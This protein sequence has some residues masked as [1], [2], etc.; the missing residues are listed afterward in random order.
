MTTRLQVMVYENRELREQAEFDGPVELGRQR[1]RDEVLFTRKKLPTG[2]RWV[3]AERG[4]VSVGRNQVLLEPLGDNRARVRNGSDRQ[5]IRFLD[6]PD[7]GPGG[8]C[9]LPLPVLIILGPNKTI[10]AQQVDSLMNS[11]ARPT[12]A[13]RLRAPVAS[14][15]PSLVVSGDTVSVETMIEWL[16]RATDVLQ[17]AAGSADFF[18]RAAR[19]V[20]ETVQLDSVRV[21]IR[22]EGA[23]RIQ[24][25]Q[26]ARDDLTSLRPAST[27]VLDR[28]L[29]EK[30]T[31]WEQPAGSAS[32]SLQGVEAVVAAP[33]LSKTGEVLGAIYGE[34]RCGLRHACGISE[35]EAKLVELVAR[36]VAAGL[37]RVDEE[38]KAVEATVQFEQ[39]FSAELAKQLAQNK[40]MLEGQ[41]REVSVLFCDIRNFTQTANRLGAERAITWCRDVLDRLSKC[42]LDEGGVLVDYIGDGLM[43]MWGAPEEQPDHATRACRAAQAILATLPGLN[44][45]W[46]CVLGGRMA[47]G[48]GINTG[49]AAVGNVGSQHKFKYGAMG[50]TVN[51]AARIQN[52]TKAFRCA[53]L[54]T[55][56]TRAALSDDFPVRRLGRVTV[57]GIKE[58]VDLYELLG[59][60]GP[61]TE[62]ARAQY[63]R[64]LQLFESGEFGP[65]A[66]VLGN[67]RSAY[68][69]DDPVLV[70]MYRSVEALVKG[71]PANHPRIDLSD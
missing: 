17:A 23:W 6:R 34:R 54:L 67:W 57:R 63:E 16:D 7:L 48:M 1:D 47:L 32:E 52:A 15:L 44:E 60:D 45:Q 58:E 70:L 64:A 25:A 28:V 36:G 2:W 8:S 24:A 69:T 13:P 55:G 20:V 21:L 65:A 41:E 38:R 66:R 42:V 12:V 62:E 30:R 11:L 29:H 4:E 35:L 53:V 33:L 46:S 19:A 3:I 40:G 39:F 37:A 49:R 51:V 56:Q 50:T 71:P 68:P 5:P 10:R 43:A 9:E 61:P 59:P 27:S 31:C 26:V 14:Q 22:R 18:D